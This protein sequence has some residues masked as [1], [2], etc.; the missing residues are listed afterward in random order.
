MSVEVQ[1]R[2]LG[3]GLWWRWRSVARHRYRLWV[4]AIVGINSRVAGGGIVQVRLAITHLE[5]AER[6]VEN[7]MGSTSDGRKCLEWR[8]CYQLEIVTGLVPSPECRDVGNLLLLAAF[9]C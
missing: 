1:Q 7:R 6:I 3:F 5:A 9:R 2:P 8:E 4:E